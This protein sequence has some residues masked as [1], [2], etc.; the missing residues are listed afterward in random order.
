[1]I[2]E[3]ADWVS[4]ENLLPVSQTTIFSLY[5]HMVENRERY[6]L[7]SMYITF[8]KWAQLILGC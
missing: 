1:M 7:D 6:L 3:L 2:R 8:K 4:G 5:P